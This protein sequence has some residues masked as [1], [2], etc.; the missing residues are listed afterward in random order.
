MNVSTHHDADGVASAVLFGLAQKIENI[1]FP[2]RFGEITETGDVKFNVCLDMK[3]FNPKWD[4]ICFDHHPGHPEVKDRKYKLSFFDVPATLGIYNKFYDKI[5][6]TERWKVAVG[7]VGD[8]QPELIP[9]SAIKAE[10]TLLDRVITVSE[11]YGQLNTFDLPLYM[12]LSSPVNA[13]CKI[14]NPYLAYQ[15]LRDAKSPYEVFYDPKATKAK[16]E[17]RSEE[18]R[19]T[20]TDNPLEIG[21]I[22]VW[23]VNTKYRITGTLGI[24]MW[25][26]TRRTTVIINEF[27]GSGSIRGVLTNLLIDELGDKYSVGGHAGYAGFVFRDVPKEDTVG[28]KKKTEEFIEDLRRIQPR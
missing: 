11:R 8:G 6:K 27:T 13:L 2:E 4:G 18:T 17:L 22:I 7:C 16:A 3:P 24:K 28:I 23:K 21:D 19:I 12:R 9:S 14:G 26:K 20:K 10:P 25:N 1:E 5:P 15:M